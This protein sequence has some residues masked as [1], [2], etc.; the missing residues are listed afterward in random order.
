[1][2]N[3]MYDTELFNEMWD[4]LVPAQGEAETVR[5]EVLRCAARM[6]YESWNNGNCN[7]YYGDYYK[8]M[9]KFLKKYGIEDDEV[10]ED[11]RWERTEPY[12]HDGYGRLVAQ[13]MEFVKQREEQYDEKNKEVH[14]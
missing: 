4:R 6:E 7:A 9:R 14:R 5:G 2:E 1:M 8:E 3:Q 10:N 11:Y 12:S 13:A